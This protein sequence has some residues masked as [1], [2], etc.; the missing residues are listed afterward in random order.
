KIIELFEQSSTTTK[1][2]AIV[3]DLRGQEFFDTALQT[4]QEL[5]SKGRFDIQFLFLEA[6]NDVLVQRYKQTRR[7]H[8]M[9]EKGMLLDGIEK[10]RNLLQEIKG[11][12]KHVIDTSDLT[13]KQLKEKLTQRFSQTNNN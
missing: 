12:S 10:E 4:I 9:S 3:L 5:E 11:K 6:R 7:K 13:P 8:P 1:K 2:L